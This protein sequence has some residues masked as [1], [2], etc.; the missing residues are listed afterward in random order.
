[1][2]SKGESSLAT[3]RQSLFVAY[4]KGAASLIEVLRAEERTL[5]LSDALAQVQA[6]AETARAAVAVFK[7]LGGGWD[8]LGP[9]ADVQATAATSSDKLL[10]VIS[11][12]C[13]RQVLVELAEK[14][15]GV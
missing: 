12:G 11:A 1:M 15:E 6:Q 4:Q 5:A 3:A 7:A 10:K 13:T 2:L 14:N 9:A 8:T